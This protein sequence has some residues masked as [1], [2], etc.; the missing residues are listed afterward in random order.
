MRIPTRLRRSRHGIFYFRIVIPCRVRHLFGGAR[1]I[2]KSLGTTDWRFAAMCSRVLSVQAELAFRAMENGVAYDPKRFNSNDPATW[3]NSNDIHKR[4]EFEIGPNGVKIKTDPN[5][6]K[7]AEDVQ[8]ALA[9]MAP[10]LADIIKASQPAASSMPQGAYP[11]FATSNHAAHI[12]NGEKNV[13]WLMP[14]WEVANRKLSPKTV[15]DYKSY[16]RRFFDWIKDRRDATE[17][18]ISTVRAAEMADYVLF[19]QLDG[20]KD[21]TIDNKHLAALG[22]F[23]KCAVR[24]EAWPREILMPTSGQRALKKSQRAEETDSY[25]PFAADELTRIFNAPILLAQKQP[26]QFWLPL[27]G[28]FTG[29]RLNELCQLALTDVRQ[30][31]GHWAISINDEEYKRLKNTASRRTVPIHPQI[32]AL[33]FIDYIEDVKA[34][35]GAERVFPYLNQDKYGSFIKNPSKHFGEYLDL[36]EI[37]ITHPQKVFHSFRSTANNVLKHAGVPEE[38]RC[39][40]IGHEHNT[41][42]HLN[43]SEPFMV[44][45]L[46]EKVIPRFSYMGLDLSGLKYERGRFAKELVRLMRWR[47]KYDGHYKKERAKQ[48]AA[49]KEG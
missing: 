42:N 21:T 20:A 35:E 34:I 44:G 7:D 18:V 1:E 41:T 19:L 12:P 38:E 2:K 23:F 28:L 26:H 47:K 22:N 24:H 48:S 14:K 36:P 16:I 9:L 39:E 13:E 27:L 33:G 49:R 40:M 30:V 43:Y 6:P 5:N 15:D 17:V 37:A 32:L 46:L 25:D 11:V 8:R 4:F 10:Q 29:A 31:D 45:Y 3:P